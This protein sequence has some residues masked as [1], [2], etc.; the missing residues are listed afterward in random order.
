MLRRL[1]I[2]GYAIVSILIDSTKNQANVRN[3][4]TVLAR[5]KTIILDASA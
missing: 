3:A 1:K 2:Q 5:T 4:K